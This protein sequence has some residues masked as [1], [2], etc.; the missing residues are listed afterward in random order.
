MSDKYVQIQYIIE[1]K[2]SNLLATTSID[3]V[4]FSMPTASFP[5]LAGS[6]GRGIAAPSRRHG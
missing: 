5:L 1:A 3:L 4:K 2:N 6:A